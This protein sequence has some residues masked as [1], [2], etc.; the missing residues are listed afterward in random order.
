MT[1]PSRF[2]APRLSR[3]HALALFAGAFCAARIAPAAA[4]PAVEVTAKIA[5]GLYEI[6]FSPS[7][8]LLYLAS[9][10]E[11]GKDNAQILALDPRSLEPRVLVS[12]ADEPAFGLGLNDRTKRLYT[13]NTRGGSVSII[14]TTSGKVLAKLAEGEKAHVRQVIVDEEADK[15]YVSVFGYREAP[16]QIWIIDGASQKITDVIKDGLEGGISGLTLDK[17]GNRLFAAAMAANEIVELDLATKAVLRR[18]P[19]GGEGP[20]NLAFDAAGK[21]LFVTNQKSG[22]LAVIDAASGKMLKSVETGEGALGVA[23]NPER[24]V[25]YVANR[26]AGTVSLVDAKSLAVIDSLATG[27]HPNTIAIDRA[28]GTAWVTNKAKSG[29]RNAPPV[30]DPRGDTV[31]IIRL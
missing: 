7:Q 9:A 16:S 30:E 21:R 11:R 22:N 15:A 20:I 12:L 28:S 18:F 27:T 1:I 3:R 8:N 17:A 5:P 29:G 25:V 26:G 14:D 2:D 19:S 13:T 24:G 23:I 10:G 6:V 4:A 31:S